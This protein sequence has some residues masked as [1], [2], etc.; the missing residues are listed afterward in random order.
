MGCR[1]NRHRGQ[2]QETAWGRRVAV[3]KTH[4]SIV[5]LVWNLLDFC[6]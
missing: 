3:S 1:A 5:E 2:E 4:T 6:F